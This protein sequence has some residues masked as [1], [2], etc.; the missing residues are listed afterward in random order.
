MSAARDSARGVFFNLFGG[1][2]FCRT[3]L[4]I[5]KLFVNGD[6]LPHQGAESLVLRN[7]LA[8]ALDGRPGGNDPSDRF[9]FDWMSEGI[10]R[11]MACGALAGAVAGG[12]AALAIALD[13]RARA[14]V[15]HFSELGAQVIAFEQQEF[16]VG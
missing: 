14:H 6:E 12:L 1:L 7:L 16:G 10:R 11:A 5:A 4:P 3:Q 15:A 9:P 8:G 2:P 13:Q